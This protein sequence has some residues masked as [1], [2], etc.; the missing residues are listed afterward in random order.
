MQQ[1]HPSTPAGC[2]APGACLFHPCPAPHLSPPRRL[3]KTGFAAFQCPAQWHAAP[4]ARPPGR[5]MP[6]PAHGV[7]QIAVSCRHVKAWRATALAHIVTA[8]QRSHATLE[9]CLTWMS[10]DG[11]Q[12][13]TG[14]GRGSGCQSSI[15]VS[16]PTIFS[17]AECMPGQH[18]THSWHMPRR[19]TSP[20]LKHASWGRYRSSRWKAL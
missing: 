15:N 18:G 1:I 3:H 6:C 20:P 9:A 14:R 10:S 13:A 16:S 4:T 17:A 12:G 5:C 11:S 7:L 2:Q 8:T 19:M